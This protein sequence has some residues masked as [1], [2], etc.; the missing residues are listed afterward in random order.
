MG[1]ILTIPST[2]S[3]RSKSLILPILLLA[4]TEAGAQHLVCGG[5]A[6]FALPDSN[7]GH[8][9][10]GFALA[11]DSLS[12]CLQ[13]QSGLVFGQAGLYDVGSDF[14]D[15]CREPVRYTEAEISVFPN[16][17][18]GLYTLRGSG[19]SACLVYDAGGRLMHRA[20]YTAPEAYEQ[21]LQI[22]FLSEG[23]YRLQLLGADGPVYQTS[24]IKINP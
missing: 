13:V 9:A 14:N 10:G 24:I 11:G 4:A 1:P 7:A 18:N 20:D 16:P 8:N 5:F 17:G 19:I 21:K 2:N 6:S 3:V 23:L 22:Q 15:Q 12:N